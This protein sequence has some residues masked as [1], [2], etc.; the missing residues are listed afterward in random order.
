[1]K[2]VSSNIRDNPDMPTWQVLQDIRKIY[3]WM[4]GWTVAFWQEIGDPSDHEAIN[5]SFSGARGFTQLF[6][7]KQTPISLKTRVWKVVE[8]YWNQTNAGIAGITPNRG[9]SV[10]II[11]HRLRRFLPSLAVINTH[12]VSG[13]WYGDHDHKQLRQDLWI[14]HWKELQSEIKRMNEAGL[15]VILGGDFNRHASDIPKFTPNQFY[16]VSHNYDHIIVCPG[17]GNAVKVS[18]TSRK[19]LT[20]SLH[21]DHNPVMADLAL[22]R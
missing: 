8:H 2:I 6:S 19:T 9:F 12:F 16:A 20:A 13:A 4:T 14:S 18:V 15:T 7:R 17:K 1:M 21:T 3:A 10:A 5:R 11:R 22:S